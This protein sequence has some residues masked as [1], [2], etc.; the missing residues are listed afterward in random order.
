MKHT[1]SRLTA[2]AV[3]LALLGVAA[4][5]ARQLKSQ[6]PADWMA[7][8]ERPERIAALKIDQ[9]IASLKLKPGNTV[10]DIGAGPGVLSLPLAKAVSPN[11]KVYSV[12]IDQQFLDHITEKTRAQNI[13]NVVPVLGTFVDPSLPAKDVDLA[14]FHDVLHHIEKRAEYLKNLAPYIKPT[15][16][17]AIVELD[18]VKG[19]HRDEPALDGQVEQD[20]RLVAVHPHPVD[21]EVVDELAPLE[22]PLVQVPERSRHRDLQTHLA[23]L[24]SGEWG[25][26]LKKEY[27]ITRSELR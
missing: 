19:S 2:L 12:E 13:T 3:V 22:L 18:P 21:G 6:P 11:G 23:D 4:P 5:G 7:R 15:G 26:A 17:I 16:R 20:R 27:C 24:V 14:L 10:A 25:S 9:I 1:T 8:M